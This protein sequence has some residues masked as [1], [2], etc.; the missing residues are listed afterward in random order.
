MGKFKP[1][2]GYK[3]S[4]TYKHHL[5]RPIL[6]PVYYIHND[7]YTWQVAKVLHKYSMV[8]I[9][10]SGHMILYIVTASA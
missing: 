7:A 10:E 3:L 8:H 2:W 9:F 5:E 6:T 4:F 1:L